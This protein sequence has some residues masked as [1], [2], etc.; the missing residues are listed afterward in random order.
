[1]PSIDPIR[2][3]QF[4]VLPGAAEL[5]EAFAA[6]PPGEVRDSAVA[7][8][9]VLARACGWSA[10]PDIPMGEPAG[11]LEHHTPPRLASPFA[12]NLTAASVDGQVVERALRGEPPHV[13]ADDMG[14]KLGMVT[15]LMAQ[16]RRHGVVF[17]G[18]DRARPG[19][20]VPLAKTS[21]NP[22]VRQVQGN[23]AKAG[24]FKKA[25]ESRRAFRALVPDPPYWREDPQSAD[26]GQPVCCCRPRPTQARSE[27]PGSGRR[28]ASRSRSRPS[29][30][31]KRE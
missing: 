14:V 19:A 12:E 26:L 20:T 3:A 8:V 24:V 28:K 6:L 21:A 25:A 17:P 13:I 23:A 11:A 2:L 1:M 4:M 5:V 9:Q 30:P 29:L 31:R 15:R 16:A 7:H 22:T 10:P 18:D 27:S